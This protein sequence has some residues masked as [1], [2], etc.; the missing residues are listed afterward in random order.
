MEESVLLRPLGGKSVLRGQLEQLLLVGQKRNVEIQLMP[1]DRE[2]NAGMDGPFTVITRKGGQ[3][4]VYMEVQGRS[5]LRTDREETRLAATRYGIIRSQALTPRETM[6]FIE[7]LL[8]E[9]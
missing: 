5:S 6:G 8:G 7:K 9:L 1:L 4:L 2:D 3:Q